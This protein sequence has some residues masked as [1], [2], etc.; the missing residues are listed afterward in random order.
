MWPI[1]PLATCPATIRGARKPRAPR[2]LAVRAPDH[3]K[4][5]AQ[6]ALWFLG[7]VLM[8][9]WKQNRQFGLKGARIIKP[10]IE[11]LN[12]IM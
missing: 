8:K 3:W 4:R 11:A 5:R 10:M 6:G 1:R 9:F 2:P 12:F 7:D